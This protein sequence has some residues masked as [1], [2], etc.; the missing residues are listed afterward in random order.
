MDQTNETP[1]RKLTM[2]QIYAMRARQ[3]AEAE[4]KTA[5]EEAA[6][7]AAGRRGFFIARARKAKPAAQN[8]A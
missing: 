6:R 1:K 8:A 2:K 5:A 4:A 3:T 7:K